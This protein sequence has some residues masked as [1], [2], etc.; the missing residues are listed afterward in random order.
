[1]PTTVPFSVSNSGQV[2]IN[3]TGTLTV[4]EGNL[5]IGSTTVTATA[6]DLNKIAGITD[7][8]ALAS[9][10][11]VLDSN[12]AIN[13]LGDMRF[14]SPG[15]SSGSLPA[16]IR[17]FDPS[18]SIVTQALPITT[19]K[20]GVVFESEQG[21][22]IVISIRGNEVTDSFF[23]TSCA[24]P[25]GLNSDFTARFVPFRI[26]S[27][28]TI[29]ITGD[30]YLNSLLLTST[31]TQL[32][33]LSGLTVLPVQNIGFAYRGNDD[34]IVTVNDS[35]VNIILASTDRSVTLSAP[36][37]MTGKTVTVRVAGTSNQVNV[38]STTDVKN[39]SSFPDC[40]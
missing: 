5:R 17:I 25:V 8:N 4:P 2:R 9:K 14:D 31:A 27:A 23:I 3:G 1:M 16:G 33:L 36:S 21:Q 39:V 11:L 24:H 34:Y 29:H 7:G 6:G 19:T 20:S 37:L 35:F 32:N 15:T 26:T 30:L 38:T 13:N 10:A 28:E 18:D 12:R 40:F 22:N